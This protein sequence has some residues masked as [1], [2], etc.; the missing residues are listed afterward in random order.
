MA[1]MIARP[2]RKRS[3]RLLLRLGAASL[4]ALAWPAAAQQHME[5]Q[6]VSLRSLV[7]QAVE[8]NPEIVAAQKG[9]E[10]ARQRPTQQASLPDPTVSVGYT[11][12]GRPYPGAGIGNQPQANA[13]LMVSQEIPFP[14]KLKLKGDMALREAEAEFQ[15][16]QAV[17]LALVSRLKQAYFRLQYT[18]AVQDLLAHHR[19]LFDA[20]LQLA[21]DRYAAGIAAQSDVFKA[22]VQIS[23]VETK[24]VR[25][26]QERKTREAEI[27]A[28]LNRAAGTPVGRPEELKPKE[29]PA[30]LEEL[31]AAARANSPVLARSRKLIERSELAV[32]AAKKEYSPDFTLN[33]GYYSMGSM[34]SMYE[35]RADV[36]VPVYFWRKQSAGV[37]EQT[38]A[39]AQAR[40]SYEA[41][42]QELRRRIQEEFLAAQASSKLMKAYQQTVAPQS[43]LALESSLLAYGDKK[44]EFL[45][46][47]SDYITS[48]D[49]AMNY[50][51]EALG[52]ELALARLEELTGQPLTDGL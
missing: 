22:R 7:R 14:G 1:S 39:L 4:V 31:F 41:G 45:A 17:Q 15:Q 30:E 29:V 32:N 34:G 10:S 38:G 49:Y 18:Y 24:L 6:R 37:A 20:L 16:Y 47:I 3:G 48:F 11:S 25:V 35:L 50:F 44:V 21:Q 13:G 43:N 46:V 5:Q 27:N 19:E 28:I 23:I 8:G 2:R 9:Y 33:A 26:E 36:K 42:D 51:D 40:R 52:Y 12:V